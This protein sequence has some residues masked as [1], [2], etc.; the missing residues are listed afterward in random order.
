M[1]ASEGHL[2]NMAH[3][4]T[5]LHSNERKLRQIS[6]FSLGELKSRREHTYHEVAEDH[7]E[8]EKDKS[9]IFSNPPVWRV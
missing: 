9:E 5:S 8:G 7:A 2:R 3:N 1:E 6:N 4:E